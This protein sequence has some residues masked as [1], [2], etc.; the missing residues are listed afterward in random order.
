MVLRYWF[1]APLYRAAWWL[2]A[3][4]GRTIPVVF[5]CG[6][7]MDLD[8]F[9]PVQRYLRPVPVVTDKPAVARHCRQRGIAV[10]RMP[11]YPQAVIMC[12]HAAHKF[13][14]ASITR[15]G[16]RHGPYHF[17]RMTAAANYN[18]FHLYLFTSRAD[19]D[20]ARE[21]GVNCGQA[22]G[23]PRLDP[24]LDGTYD[25]TRLDELRRRYALDP[26]KPCVLFTA[27][28][29]GSGMS[30]YSE[31]AHR[32][33]ELTGRYNVLVT[34]HPW[35]AQ[36]ERDKLAAIPGVAMLRHEDVLPAML[37]AGACVGDT[38]SILAE[39]C[40]LDVPLVT[41]RLPAARRTLP[42]IDAMLDEMSERVES[43]EAMCAAI[44]ECLASPGG[45][46]PQ[47]QAAAAKMFDE[48]DG[49]AGARAAQAIL[50]LIPS[51][52]P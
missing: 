9:A 29:T 45:R 13:P 4:L 39:C 21:M 37:L 10:Q 16:M 25:A 23:Y 33:H 41:W 38:S 24:A 44:G 3:R 35:F 18:R 42:E 34:L 20:A 6:D 31:W 7:A 46:R 19:M 30:A 26:G 1:T 28:W 49:Q 15:V 52:R 36:S 11:V 2:H 32:L 12:R 47:R 8:L 48:L 22:V 27:T 50:Q 51:L 17:K 40:A 43:F 5:Y 14:A